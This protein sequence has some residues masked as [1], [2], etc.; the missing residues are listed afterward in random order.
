MLVDDHTL[1][2]TRKKTFYSRHKKDLRNLILDAV[3]TVGA[4][5]N[6][7]NRLR[8]RRFRPAQVTDWRSSV[9]DVAKRVDLDC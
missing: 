6:A 3:G 2:C 9:A 4:V 5:L 1:V 7:T 8:R